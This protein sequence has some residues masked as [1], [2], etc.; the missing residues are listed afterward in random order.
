MMITWQRRKTTPDEVG[1]PL[2]VLVCGTLVYY[3]CMFR[4]SN[5]V[6]LFSDLLIVLLSSLAVLGLLFRQINVAIPVDPLEWKISQDAAN[7]VIA[8]L[9]NTIGASVSVL[10]VAATG[11][12]KRLFFKVV[13]TLYV[14]S[15]L[16]RLVPSVT[17]AYA[18]SSESISTYMSQFF[19]Q[20]IAPVQN[21]HRF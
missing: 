18:E 15:V 1:K 16:G 4:N 5:L 7:E 11:H 6:S 19:R 20:R 12:D 2:V 14:L 8:R 10:K 9:V 17:V 3:H 21:P 13:A